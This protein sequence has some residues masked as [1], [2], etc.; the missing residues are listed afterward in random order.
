MDEMHL[1]LRG[2]EVIPRGVTLE[3]EKGPIRN[4]GVV[5]YGFGKSGTL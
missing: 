5:R 3:V 1:T 4:G 2:G